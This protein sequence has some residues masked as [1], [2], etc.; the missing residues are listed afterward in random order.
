MYQKICECGKLQ[1]YKSKDAFKLAIKTNSKCK[2]CSNKIN[3]NI[4]KKGNCNN[5]LNDTYISHYWLGFICADGHISNSNR[6]VVTLSIKDK[7]HIEKLSKFLGNIPIKISK[8]KYPQCKVSIMDTSNINNLCIKYN[9][10]SNKTENPI[11]FN[12]IKGIRNKLSFIYGF[13]DGD[14]CIGN[15]HK[16]KNFNLRIKCHKEWINILNIFSKILTG[17]EKAKINNQGYSQLNIGDSDL[18][19]KI[20]RIGM[21]LQL[22]L[23]KRKWDVIDFN[24]T[25][26]QNKLNKFKE[27]KVGGTY[28]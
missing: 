2:S 26:N 21:L 3:A 16:R 5:L 14:G 9:I 8:T 1:K 17:E 28:E 7:E 20:K 11:N 4:Y 15:L 19:K 24:Y 10:V 18:L 22:P 12:V 27:K 13:I 25:K 6:L 23:L